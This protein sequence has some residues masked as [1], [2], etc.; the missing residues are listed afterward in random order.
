MSAAVRH[1][2]GVGTILFPDSGG[3]HSDRSPCLACFIF[4]CSRAPNTSP[5]ASANIIP[6]ACPVDR[7]PE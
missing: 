7:D 5:L 6:P 1:A 4:W 2:I 3:S